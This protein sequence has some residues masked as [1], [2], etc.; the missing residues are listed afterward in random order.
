MNYQHLYAYLDSRPV[1]EQIECMRN[2][3]RITR[4]RLPSASLD[5]DHETEE[6]I[7]LRVSDVLH[8]LK[9]LRAAQHVWM[10]QAVWNRFG[11]GAD[12]VASDQET[13]RLLREPQVTTFLA[14]INRTIEE[15]INKSAEFTVPATATLSVETP[16]WG[17]STVSISSSPAGTFSP[18]QE[19]GSKRK[20]ENE[21]IAA[22]RLKW[23]SDMVS[24][25][26]FILLFCIHIAPIDRLHLLLLGFRFEKGCFGKGGSGELDSSCK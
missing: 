19:V 16:V 20:Y 22:K 12:V 14:R 21:E 24:K 25:V 10:Q 2:V 3:V 15:E 8:E 6:T 13:T 26:Y 17:G 11:S 5:R 18:D 9:R 1:D 7:V 23:T 4:N